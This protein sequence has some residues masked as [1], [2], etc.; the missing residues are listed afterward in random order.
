MEKAVGHL[1]LLE[2]KLKKKNQE[3]KKSSSSF[4]HHHHP[5]LFI[6]PNWPHRS[7]GEKYIY[8]KKKKEEELQS[9]T[10][11]DEPRQR[12]SNSHSLFSLLRAAVDE[13]LANH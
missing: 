9:T 13:R 8:K 3:K 5:V 10:M 1:F 6:F 11:I 2:L 7:K 4:H 12:V